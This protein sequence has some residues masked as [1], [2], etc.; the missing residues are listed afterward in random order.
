MFLRVS[1]CHSV[2][3]RTIRGKQKLEQLPCE[4]FLQGFE[5]S[6]AFLQPVS[7]GKKSGK[8][9]NIIRILS[10]HYIDVVKYY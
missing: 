6:R 10:Q 3:A 2:F 8:L 5:F 9:Q 7:D 1:V 4:R